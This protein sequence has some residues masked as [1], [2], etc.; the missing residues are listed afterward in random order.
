MT[1]ID[2]DEAERH[3]MLQ[4]QSD[5]LQLKGERMIMKRSALPRLP[6]MKG[7]ALAEVAA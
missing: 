1:T 7:A 5:M 4:L 2:L 3:D 6:Y